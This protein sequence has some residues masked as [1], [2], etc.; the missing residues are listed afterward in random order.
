MPNRISEARRSV[1]V[2]ALLL[3]YPWAGGCMWAGLGWAGLGWR[4]DAVPDL[5]V[6]SL[7]GTRH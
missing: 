7:T 6:L 1:S 2:V 3:L 5:S 4:V